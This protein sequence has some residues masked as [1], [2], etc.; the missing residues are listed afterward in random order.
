MAEAEGDEGTAAELEQE[1]TRLEAAV[2]KPANTSLRSGVKKL[3]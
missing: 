1:R 3:R 2:R